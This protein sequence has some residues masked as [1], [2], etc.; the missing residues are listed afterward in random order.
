MTA[1]R[2]RIA[3]PPFQTPRAGRGRSVALAAAL[4]AGLLL[5]G[6]PAAAEPVFVPQDTY[7]LSAG[8]LH[9]FGPDVVNDYFENAGTNA[10]F[11]D[12]SFSTTVYF[13][14]AYLGSDGGIYITTKT[15]A[16][17]NALPSPPPSPFTVALTVTMAND[18]GETASGTLSLETTY[19]RL[20]ASSTPPPQPAFKSTCQTN[21]YQEA[22]P[23]KLISTGTEGCFDSEGTDPQF[24][25]VIFSTGEYYDKAEVVGG[26]V[27]VQAKSAEDLRA[28]PN[29]P[30]SPFEVTATATMT[31]DEGQTATADL[32][33]RT[34]YDFIDSEVVKSTPKPKQ[35]ADIDAAPGTTVTINLED[36][37]D[38][39]GTEAEFDAI[40]VKPHS[41]AQY[42]ESVGW[43][44]TGRSGNVIRVD[45]SSIEVKVKSA[46]DLR[47]LG[48]SGTLTARIVMGMSNA[49]GRAATNEVTLNTTVPAGD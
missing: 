41:A 1:V 35:M 25:A 39:V 4:A 45:W 11:T 44:V 26:R 31:N 40:Q 46:D 2:H 37:F 32:V 47:A 14:E 5:D 22:P 17:L 30:R 21:G 43:T 28:L 49:E 48:H 23:G 18:E 27:Y 38:H 9:S 13:D 16:D 20:D 36:A 3:R 8:R 7:S 24:T 12:A 10:R 34:R 33:Y 15:A 42:Y 29:Q 19:R 6:A